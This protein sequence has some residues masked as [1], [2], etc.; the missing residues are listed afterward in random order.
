MFFVKG[1]LFDLGMI[2]EIPGSIGFDDGVEDGEQFAHG[3]GHSDLEGFSLIFQPFR[4]VPDEWVMP[5]SAERSHVES[6]S[7]SNSPATDVSF[8]GC[9]SAIGVDRSDTDESGDFFAVDLSEFWEFGN[10]SVCGDRSDSWDTGQEFL[11]SPGFFLGLA[12]RG[13]LIIDLFDLV[14]EE[15]DDLLD[16]LAHGGSF[17]GFEVIFLPVNQLDELSSPC[18]E[19]LPFSLIF[20]WFL[21]EDEVFGVTG[22]PGQQP[23]INGVGFGQPA[24]ASGE[25]ADA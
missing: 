3:S 13:D 19:I 9:G 24:H 5:D 7:D 11:Q 8:F 10:E 6:A 20:G 16:V 12:E 2:D 18:D 25:I 15:R 17:R 21:T 14:L 23:G 22:E 4:K 1:F